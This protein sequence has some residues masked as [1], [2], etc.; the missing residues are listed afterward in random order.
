MT[1]AGTV[2]MRAMELARLE[3]LGRVVERRLTQRQAA[4]Q[5]GLSLHQVQRLCRR[6]TLLHAGSGRG[7]YSTGAKLERACRPQ[8]PFSR[9]TIQ[10]AVWVA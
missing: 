3:V 10:S 7:R 8:R 5:P 2:T 1:W 4:E 6:G 9:V